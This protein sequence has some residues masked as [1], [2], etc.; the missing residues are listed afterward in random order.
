M[1]RER[2]Q[3]KRDLKIADNAATELFRLERVRQKEEKKQGRNASGQEDV[4]Q[5]DAKAT[6]VKPERSPKAEPPPPK[7]KPLRAAPPDAASISPEEQ[8][9]NKR[10][11]EEKQKESV[12]MRAENA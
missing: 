11:F 8:A 5:D 6:P 12:T 2:L 3:F 1:E 7:A 9:E 10:I 4:L